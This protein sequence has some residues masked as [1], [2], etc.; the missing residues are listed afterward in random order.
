MSQKESTPL[1]NNESNWASL[2][3]NVFESAL[4]LARKKNK[5]KNKKK[6]QQKTGT[7]VNIWYFL[8]AISRHNLFIHIINMPK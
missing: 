6:Q 4:V 2:W 5:N 8:S 3:R 1:S 7:P